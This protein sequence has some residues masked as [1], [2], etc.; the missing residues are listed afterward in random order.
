MTGKRSAPWW[1]WAV[2]AALACFEPMTHALFYLT[3]GVP[4]RAERVV[5]S[6]LHTN[7]SV[8]YLLSMRMFESGFEMPFASCQAAL[9]GHHMGYFSAPAYWLYGLVG[10]VANGI[11]CPHFVA[12]GIANGIGGFFYL[13]MVF[14]F[15]REAVPRCANRAFLLFSLGG[16][17]GSIMFMVLWVAF[18]EDAAQFEAYSTRFALYELIEGPHLFPVLHFSRLY[19]TVALAFCFGSLTAFFKTL[20]AWCPYHLAFAALLLAVA[21]FINMRLGALTWAVAVLYLLCLRDAPGQY[22]VK[23]ALGYAAGC[24]MGTLAAWTFHQ[25]HPTI[26]AN[27]FALVRQAMWLT[28]FL[29][30]AFFFLLLAVPESYRSFRSMSGIPR[31]AVWAMG[32]YLAAFG[33]FFSAY[34]LYYGNVLV[35]R[36]G[37]VADAISDPAL[38]GLAAGLAIG[39]FRRSKPVSNDSPPADAA[40]AWVVLWAMVFTVV[41]VSAWG[42]GWFLRF[43]PQRCMMFLLLPLTILAAHRLERQAE[44][45]GAATFKT[46]FIVLCG[47]WSILFHVFYFQGAFVLSGQKSYERI[48]VSHVS[49]NDYADAQQL[50]P[51]R[52]LA[53]YPWGDIIALWPGYQSVYGVGAVMADQ[54]YVDMGAEVDRFF[55]LEDDDAFRQEFLRKWCVDYVFCPVMTAFG[56]KASA[57]TEAMPELEKLEVIHVPPSDEVRATIF[58][59]VLDNNQ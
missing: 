51:G 5:W 29:S 48:R 28:P 3:D 12:L 16:G 56:W 14:L 41:A 33:A 13:A 1:V 30:A 15:L 23:A 18:H 40:P 27:V 50:P 11:G 8:I 26:T 17:L 57:V 36:D 55:S 53:P 6:G 10:V 20:R 47:C 59:V 19:Y 34:Q 42:G 9:G 7:D 46:G 44:S 25:G 37:A 31:M 49:A 52:I 39:F 2:C 21:S 35:A 43:A 24:F 45:R 54:P 32:G 58:R 22:R 38:L 4:L